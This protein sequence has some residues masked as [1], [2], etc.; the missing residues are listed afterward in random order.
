MSTSITV[1]GSTDALTQ[2]SERVENAQPYLGAVG[3]DMVA[4]VKQR[5]ATSTGPDGVRW[6]ANTQATIMNYLSKRGAFSGKTGKILAKGQVLA[7]NKRPL[8]G[9]SGDLARQQIYQATA[10]SLTVGSTMVY[11]AMMQFGG[12][13]AIYS[14]LWGD[15]PARQYMP[16]TADGNLY[17]DEQELIINQLRDYLQ[18]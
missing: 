15:I 6:K 14:H 9:Q 13:K 17:P 3:E 4:R 7:A 8:Q 11:A 12:K 16:I 1:T 2:M 18:G 10:N 5:F